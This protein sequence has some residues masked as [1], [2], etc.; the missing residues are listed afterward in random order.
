MED[1]RD[2]EHTV[3]TFSKLIGRLRPDS[4]PLITRQASGLLARRQNS[5]SS[6]KS[7][8]LSVRWKS[9]KKE[10]DESIE[11]ILWNELERPQSEVAQRFNIDATALK[12]LISLPEMMKL[13]C[14]FAWHYH[15]EERGH[16]DGDGRQNDDGTSYW[17]AEDLFFELQAVKQG[18]KDPRRWTGLSA[19]GTKNKNRGWDLADHLVRF[20]LLA[21][22]CRLCS[23]QGKWTAWDWGFEH[24]V[25]FYLSILRCYTIREAKQR[26]LA[27]TRSL[28]AG[29]AGG[30]SG[31]GSGGN[32][33]ASSPLWSPASWGS[34]Q[35]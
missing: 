25:A 12:E 27:K 34:R 2:A 18:D 1:L 28:G 23:G 17:T 14:E 20:V 29:V 4:T 19:A 15:H 21:E 13:G 7:T 33:S 3:S 9:K 6:Q 32:S 35:G 26:E 24:K 31:S 10:W 22:Q 8:S 16:G 30:G 11:G 5:N